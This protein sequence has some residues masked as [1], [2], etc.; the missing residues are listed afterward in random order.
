LKS[1]S[2]VQEVKFRADIAELTRDLPFVASTPPMTGVI[3]SV[4]NSSMDPVDGST[5]EMW[6]K[7]L[8]GIYSGMLNANSAN[9]QLR[10]IIATGHEILRVGRSG[11][12]NAIRVVP[13]AELQDK[14]GSQCFIDPAAMA[15]GHICLSDIEL[16]R[17]FG[18]IATP[19]LPVIRAA[20]PLY[21]PSGSLLGIA[22]INQSL[23][24][25]FSELQNIVEDRRDF[26]VANDKGE[27]LLHP[28]EWSSKTGHGLVANPIL[29]LGCI[30]T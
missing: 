8:A 10:L 11:L 28:M 9:V 16:N 4:A 5:D 15:A 21:I 18:Q 17:E 13:E 25:S 22:V 27:Y 7:R 29:P 20:T 12:N 1:E 3:R 19:Q 14:S 26:Y 23:Q 6:L 2:R 24:S 30:W